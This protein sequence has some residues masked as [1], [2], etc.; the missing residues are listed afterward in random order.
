MAGLA[1]LPAIEL[2]YRQKAATDTKQTL[3]KRIMLVSFLSFAQK[4][5]FLEEQ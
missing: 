5:S 3:Q 1:P 4:F 2:N